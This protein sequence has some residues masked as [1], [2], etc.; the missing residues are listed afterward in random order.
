MPFNWSH[1]ETR[2][3]RRRRASF[4]GGTLLLGAAAMVM[5]AC[6]GSSSHTSTATQ[7][8]ATQPAATSPTTGASSQPAASSP[9]VMTASNA[10]F[11]KILVNSKGLTLYTAADDTATHSGC[12]GACLKFWPPLLLPAGQS[13]PV[14][15]SGLT[16]LGTLMAPSGVQVTYKGKPLYTVVTDKAPGQVTGQG[17]VDSDGKWSV[18]TVAGTATTQPNSPA[19]APTSPPTTAAPSSGGASF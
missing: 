9:T 16:G 4:T 2:P 12:T 8:S 19:P 14:A 6:G 7:P 1:D 10:K 3:V 13:Q 15:G 17:V 5:A 18:A 11:G